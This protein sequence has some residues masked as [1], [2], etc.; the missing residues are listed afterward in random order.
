MVAVVKVIVMVV[1][2]VLGVVQV[3][4]RATV[5]V[6]L[7]VQVYQDKDMLVVLETKQAFMLPVVVVENLKLVKHPLAEVA[8]V[9]AVV[10]FYGI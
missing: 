7:L 8:V 5:E 6:V 1:V 3:I 9:K 2:L 4:V 10:V